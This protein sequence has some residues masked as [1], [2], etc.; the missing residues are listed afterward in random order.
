MSIINAT[1]VFH[2]YCV[3]AEPS[4]AIPSIFFSVSHRKYVGIDIQI[5]RLAQR[6]SFYKFVLGFINDEHFR[7]NQATIF[8]VINK[9]LLQTFET[10][11]F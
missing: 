7:V 5:F 9:N 11:R 8:N 4:K 1:I 10:E 6:L 3:N 2:V